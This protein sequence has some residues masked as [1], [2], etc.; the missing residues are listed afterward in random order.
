M[1]TGSEGE[2][3]EDCAAFKVGA[4]VD[5]LDIKERAG[6]VGS[7]MEH[8]EVGTGRIILAGLGKDAAVRESTKGC[9]TKGS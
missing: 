5:E 2:I 4:G 6:I 7:G 8:F 9:G 1:G 3:G